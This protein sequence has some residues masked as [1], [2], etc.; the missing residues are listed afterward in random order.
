MDDQ[1]LPKPADRVC[2]LRGPPV[3]WTLPLDKAGRQPAF[4]REIL[5]TRAVWK[6]AEKGDPVTGIVTVDGKPVAHAQ[7]TFQP[8][9]EGQGATTRTN[10]T[11]KYSASL[12][13]GSY[14]I[15]IRATDEK[16]QSKEK[17]I[18]PP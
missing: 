1:L 17:A 3:Y 5:W 11:G 16:Q 2:R 13:P 6:E 4:L 8:K 15:T 10:K 18:T 14:R 9:D 12:P 7:V